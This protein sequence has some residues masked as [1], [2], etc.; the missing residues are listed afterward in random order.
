MRL[1]SRLLLLAGLTLAAIAPLA[2]SA[3]A[4]PTAAATRVQPVDFN[5]AMLDQD[6]EKI[7]DCAKV[8]KVPATPTQAETLKCAKEI[9]LTL[10]RLAWG[11]LNKA[12]P[13]MSIDDAKRRFQLMEKVYSSPTPIDISNNDADLI[14]RMIIKG[15]YPPQWIGRAIQ[16]LDAVSK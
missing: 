15:G 5:A 14:E 9:T 3:A 16:M 1:L 6:G 13:N 12:D 7:M 4:Q 10:G 11:A 2:T 8:E